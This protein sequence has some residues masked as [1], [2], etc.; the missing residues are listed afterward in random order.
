[1][2]VP[3]T[4]NRVL[5]AFPWISC[6]HLSPCDREGSDCRLFPGKSGCKLP[7]GSQ[8][9]ARWHSSTKMSQ[10][11][12]TKRTVDAQKPGSARFTVWDTDVSGFGFR[13]TPAG[14]R[15]YVLKYRAR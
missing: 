15:A 12:L 5:G 1:M 14:E 13:V 4:A 2:A 7:S 8:V 9:V 10:A 6:G 11:K 3:K